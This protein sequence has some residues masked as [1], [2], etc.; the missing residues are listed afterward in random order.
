MGMKKNERQLFRLHGS[1]VMRVES[2]V[3]VG[4][5]SE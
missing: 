1:T 2:R 4:D 3:R 5:R